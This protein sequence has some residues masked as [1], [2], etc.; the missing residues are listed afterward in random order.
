MLELGRTYLTIEGK[1]VTMKNICNP[2][3]PFET[4]EDQYGIH[5]Y[6]QD[7]GYGLGRVTGS[8]HDFSDFRNILWPT[9]PVQ[10]P[11]GASH[12]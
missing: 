9:L 3:E 7:N 4:A 6:S 11:T 8:S 12:V 10:R 5:R 2:G 1:S